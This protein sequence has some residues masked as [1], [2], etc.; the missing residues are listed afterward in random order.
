MALS[1][2]LPIHKGMASSSLRALDAVALATNVSVIMKWG[3]KCSLAFARA[4]LHLWVASSPLTNPVSIDT[5]PLGLPAWSYGLWSARLIGIRL[6]PGRALEEPVRS[7]QRGLLPG[8]VDLVIDRPQGSV[9]ELNGRGI[10][11]VAVGTFRE[12]DLVL[13]VPRLAVVLADAG[14][15]PE[16]RP[17]LG[18]ADN[19]PVVA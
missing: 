9:R 7:H 15:G 19:Q 2:L 17:A 6:F 8:L 13:G 16:R 4:Q 10:S 3:T 18:V 1:L 5:I 11:E 14:V 12:L